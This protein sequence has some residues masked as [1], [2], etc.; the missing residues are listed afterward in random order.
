MQ[1]LL[2][3]V[4]VGGDDMKSHYFTEN[5]GQQ[6]ISFVECPTISDYHK[7]ESTDGKSV[8]SLESG[9]E[10]NRPISILTPQGGHY[11]CLSKV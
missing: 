3:Q 10:T 2:L 4:A 9:I 11:A 8:R 7:A 1:T 5:E 6:N